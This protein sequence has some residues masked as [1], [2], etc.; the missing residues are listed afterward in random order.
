[1]HVAIQSEGLDS[2]TRHE[3]AVAALMQLDAVLVAA[4]SPAGQAGAALRQLASQAAP[5]ADLRVDFGA[6]RPVL[7]EL[8][9]GLTGNRQVLAEVD[10]PV[11]A[12]PLEPLRGALAEA[13]RTVRFTEASRALCDMDFLSAAMASLLGIDAPA[14]AL[15][16]EAG[17]SRSLA[18]VLRNVRARARALLAPQIVE[19][20]VRA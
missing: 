16:A 19:A 1:V 8:M 9:Q 10:W 15:Q 11:I 3:I 18:G 5:A 13:G 2:V 7:E 6:V 17:T 14:Q 12:Y 20:V 4:T